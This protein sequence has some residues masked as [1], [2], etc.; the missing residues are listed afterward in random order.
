MQ[1]TLDEYNR[2][3]IDPSTVPSS[4]PASYPW[5]KQIV[6][7]EHLGGKDLIRLMWFSNLLLFLCL[8]F[9]ST[10]NGQFEGA[11]ED[12]VTV[13][14]AFSE[15]T[16]AMAV[17]HLGIINRLTNRCAAY[18]EM[19]GRVLDVVGASVGPPLLVPLCSG[20][21]GSHA[22][23]MDVDE[24]EVPLLA[25]SSDVPVE[26]SYA[27]LLQFVSLHQLWSLWCLVVWC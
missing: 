23:G 7:S 22:V 18:E 17:Q 24:D 16:M 26:S 5:F 3:L 20:A 27:L 10:V 19:V 14:R 9:Y 21:S 13:S 12:S 2:G 15:E 11:S 4:P 1:R 8:I 25:G 6:Y